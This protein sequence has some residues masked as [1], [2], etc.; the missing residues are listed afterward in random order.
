LTTGLNFRWRL[1]DE[2]KGFSERVECIGGDFFESVPAGYSAYLLRFILRDWEDKK[3]VRILANCRKAMRDDSVLVIVD[4]L[5]EDKRN[6]ADFSKLLDIALM[7]A[8]GGRVRTIS[9]SIKLLEASGF[10]LKRAVPTASIFTIL[11]AVPA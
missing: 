11:E 9:E 4:N 7:C 3:A 10:K 1:E 2:K 6:K 8:T 5:A